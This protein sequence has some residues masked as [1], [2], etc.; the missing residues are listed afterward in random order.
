MLIDREII[1]YN[2]IS[3]NQI[4]IASGGRS[5]DSSLKS[6]HDS[7]SLAHKYEFNGLSLRKI[8]KDHDIDPREKILVN[9]LQK[10]ENLEKKIK[11]LNSKK[12]TK[13]EN[14]KKFN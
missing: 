5:V 4:T 6:N 2:A 11:T 13:N 7:S 12:I 9:L 3:N 8:N 1:A 10:V 14:H